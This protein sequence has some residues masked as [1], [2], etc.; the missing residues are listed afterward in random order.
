LWE[1][2]A[3]SADAGEVW[4]AGP[5]EWALP[6]TVAGDLVLVRRGGVLV[7]VGAVCA[8]PVGFEFYLT[9]GFD[10]GQAAGRRAWVRGDRLLGFHARTPQERESVTR[11]TVGF[12]DGAAA[13]SVALLRRIPPGEP[14]L[15]FAGGD[16]VIGSYLSVLRAESRWWVSPLPPPGPVEFR[17]F[18]HGAAGPDGTASM[19]AGVIVAAAGRSQV[20]WPA[21]AGEPG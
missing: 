3:V 2:G 21:P 14:V 11:I 12:A 8:Y 4:A 20:L 15:R 5:P 19:D 16:S 1:D 7:S 6:V 13:D 17:V 9:V 18:L 10:R